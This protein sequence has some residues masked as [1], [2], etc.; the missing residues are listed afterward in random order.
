MIN[1]WLNN[2]LLNIGKFFHSKNINNMDDEN[3]EIE[4]NEIEDIKNEDLY[5]EPK[6]KI[7]LGILVGHTESSPGAR[8]VA[9]I[10]DYEYGWNLELAKYFKNIAHKH[11]IE[12]FVETRDVIGIAGAYKNLN[13]KGVD[14]VIE[15]HFNAAAYHLASGTETIY[16]TKISKEFAQYIQNSMLES[17]NLR[18][19]GIKLPVNGRGQSNLS[20]LSNIPTI[21]IEPGFGSNEKDSKVMYEKKDIMVDTML[22]YVNK[23]FNEQ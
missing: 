19:R 20:Q 10:D 6:I 21:I 7:K 23:Y 5:V 14:A 3:N 1:F 11:N 2:F 4:N 22:K 17:L 16:Y 18:D 12:V 9:P 15:L 8:A 13:D